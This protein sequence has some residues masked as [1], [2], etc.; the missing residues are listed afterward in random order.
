M[1]FGIVAG[2]LSAL[3]QSGSYALSRAFMLKHKSRLNL[4]FYSQLAMG[5]LGVLT[6]PL[7]LPV[8]RFPWSG[9][10]WG[11]MAG[12]FFAF[13]IGQFSFFQALREIEASRLS[14]LFGLKIV[15]LAVIFIAVE[16]RNLNF[17]QWIAVVLSA[18]AAMGM[19]LTGGRLSLKGLAWLALT[20]VSYSAC[21]I[22]ETGIIKMMPGKSVMLESLGIVALSYALLGFCTLPVLALKND[23]RRLLIDAVPFSVA[24]Y[25]AM[26]FIYVCFGLI[27]VVFGN[28]IQASRGII[29]VALGAVLLHYGFDRLEPRVGRK[30]WIRRFLMAVV[31]VAAMCLYTYARNRMQ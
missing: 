5:A 6:L 30:A 31:M 3:F 20:L 4:L 27:G 14:S 9:A 28:I 29:S 25:G 17:L 26:I 16:Q 7:I 2:V 12:W 8:V 15:V 22:V 11:L 19:N 1:I 23:H 10:F 21:D 13:V 18:V 24:W